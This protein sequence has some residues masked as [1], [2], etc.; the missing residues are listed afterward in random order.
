MN[1]MR[2]SLPGEESKPFKLKTGDTIQ[3]GVDYRGSVDN[4]TKCVSMTIELSLIK[5]GEKPPMLTAHMSKY[6]AYFLSFCLV[7]SRLVLEYS[8]LD[9]PF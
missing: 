4:A 3:L 2:L 1:A 7:L 8:P 6:I 9:L 5:P